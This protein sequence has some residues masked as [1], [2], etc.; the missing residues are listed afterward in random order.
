MKICESNFDELFSNLSSNSRN[1]AIV[2]LVHGLQN[3][4]DGRE[5]KGRKRVRFTQAFATLAA[6]IKQKPGSALPW[7]NDLPYALLCPTPCAH[8]LSP[9]SPPPPPGPLNQCASRPS[10]IH[11]RS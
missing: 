6:L 1:I 2:V 10:T 4:K 3:R 8:T 7:M 11:P 9:R 5:G